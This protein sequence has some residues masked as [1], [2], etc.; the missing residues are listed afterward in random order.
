MARISPMRCSRG[1]VR[2]AC[3]VIWVALTDTKRVAVMRCVAWLFCVFLTPQVVVIICGSTFQNQSN[4]VGKKNVFQSNQ[5]ISNNTGE[6][7]FMAL[8]L[9]FT[10]TYFTSRVLNQSL[11][12][13]RRRTRIASVKSP[14]L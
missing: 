7:I 12:R 13:I 1:G 2:F 14:E 11:V 8:P 6:L 10:I 3:A 9:I 5:Y 4:Y